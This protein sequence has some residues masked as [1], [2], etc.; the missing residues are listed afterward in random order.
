MVERERDDLAREFDEHRAAALRRNGREKPH[1]LKPIRAISEDDLKL[2][3]ACCGSLKDQL[4]YPTGGPRR[5]VP[6]QFIP[7]DRDR[8]LLIGARP[9]WKRT[10]LDFHREFLARCR[11]GAENRDAPLH[12]SLVF[13]GSP[14]GAVVGCKFWKVALA[15]R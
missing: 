13:V 1:R 4:D 3:C 15:N 5:V 8:S 11:V 12:D 9:V 6:L 14:G 7:G 10:V 2:V